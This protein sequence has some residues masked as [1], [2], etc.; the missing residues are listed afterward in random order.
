MCTETSFSLKY[1]GMAK[2]LIIVLGLE[3]YCILCWK[4]QCTTQR[5]TH[6]ES[7]HPPL[8]HRAMLTRLTFLRGCYRRWPAASQPWSWRE[9]RILASSVP[10]TATRSLLVS[11]Y[12]NVVDKKK[13]IR[14]A[15]LHSTIIIWDWEVRSK[16]NW[17]TSGWHLHGVIHLC[18]GNCSFHEWLVLINYLLIQ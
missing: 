6:T 9:P 17:I 8:A 4:Q 12:R 15:K 16:S 10:K 13:D 1:Y 18:V 11:S 3:K 14:V 2:Y 5:R 7:L